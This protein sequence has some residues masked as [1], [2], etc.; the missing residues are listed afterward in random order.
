MTLPS[1]FPLSMSQIATELGLSLPL[2]INHPWVITLAGKSALPV[3]FSDL[4]DRSGRYDGSALAQSTGGQFPTIYATL[5][6]AMMFG[7][8]LSTIGFNNAPGNVWTLTISFSAPPTPGVFPPHWSGNLKVTNNTTNT[9]FVL[10]QTST[11]V[12]SITQ[13]S[14]SNPYANVVRLGQTDSFTILPST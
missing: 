12:W 2:S 10:P 13:T 14:A 6:P 8:T 11:Y 4:L 7:G 1:S 5:Y 3:S 9:S